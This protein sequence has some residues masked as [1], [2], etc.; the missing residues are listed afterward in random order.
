MKSSLGWTLSLPLLADLSP[1]AYSP[2]SFP[3]HNTAMLASD[4]S[5]SIIGPYGRWAASLRPDPPTLSLRAT[6]RKKLSTW[7]K[8]ALAKVKELMASPPLGV[9]ATVTVEKKYTYDGLDMEELSWQLP[10]GRPT[11]ALLLKPEGTSKPLPGILA[12]HDHSGEKYYGYAKITR[13]SDQQDRH[14]QEHQAGYYGGIAWANE[15]AKRGYVVLVPDAFL[16]GSRRVYYEDVEGISWGM[17]KTNNRSDAEISSQEDI[18]TYNAWASDHE[19]VVSKSLFC[20][21]TTWPG[22]VLAEDQ[23]ALTILSQRSDVDANRLGCAGLSGGGLRT[24]YLAGLDERIRCAVSVGFMSTWNDFLLHKAYTHTWMV[25]TPLLPN[26]LEFP[27][28][29]GLRAPLPVMVQSNNQD[30][31]YTLPEMQKADAIL[32]EVYDLAKASDAYQGRFYDGDHKFDA[33]MQADA[34]AWFDRWLG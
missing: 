28:I 10:Y 26:Y 2:P 24:V 34:F 6:P 9:P 5:K 22:V 4:D 18:N 31:L 33:T 13:T 8:E 15:M 14:M 1:F 32:R 29:L 27:E 3:T 21:G 23:A 7:K 20:A 19:H 16:F 12:L 11:K 30:R 17:T 25:Y